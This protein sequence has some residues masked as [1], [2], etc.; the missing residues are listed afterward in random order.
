VVYRSLKSYGDDVRFE[1]FVQYVLQEAR[2]G[3]YQLDHH[4]R[5]QYQLCRPCHLNYDFVGHYETLGPDAAH[6]LQEIA[7]RRHRNTTDTGVRFPAADLDSR[8]RNSGGLLRKFYANVSTHNVRRLLRLYRRDYETFGYEIPHEI[9]R[10]LNI[11]S[12]VASAG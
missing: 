5:P 11:K 1:E 6:V 12:K 2:R 9:R 3:P 7:R 10:K 4:W 8:N